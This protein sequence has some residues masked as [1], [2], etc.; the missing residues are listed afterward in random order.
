MTE[1]EAASV[2]ILNTLFAAE[3]RSLVPRLA[4]M[5]NFVSWASADDLGVVKRMIAEESEQQQ[6][7]V[8]QIARC[9]GGVYPTAADVTTANLHYLDL[10]TVMPRVIASTESLVGL[11]DNPSQRASR[12]SDAL[13]PEAAALIG[14]IAQRH[15]AHLQQLR[16]LHDQVVP[17]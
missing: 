13:T 9:G 7:L 12:R 16:T 8:E 5:S 3:R 2:E 11:Y 6:W 4:E 1:Q 10:Q 14:R 15:Q 17:A